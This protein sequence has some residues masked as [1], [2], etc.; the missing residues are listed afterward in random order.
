MKKLMIIAMVLAGI[1]FASL[2]QN[3]AIEELAT[4]YSDQEGYTVVSL[5]GEMIKYM[6]DSVDMGNVNINDLMEDVSS[7][8]VITGEKPDKQFQA[9]ARKAVA[10]GSYTTLMSVSDQGQ[11]IRFLLAP[12]GGGK[13]NEPKKNE[14]VMLI[15]GPD[16]NVLISIVGKYKVKQI[17][18]TDDGQKQKED[19]DAE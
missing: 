3:K 12:V 18:K 14:F 6:G 8:I 2:A 19:K 16:E 4:K 10:A 5:K 11:T 9:D 17:S 13:K 15:L 1:P 7:I